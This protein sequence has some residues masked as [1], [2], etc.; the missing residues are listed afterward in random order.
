M[1]YPESLKEFDAPT[2]KQLEALSNDSANTNSLAAIN[3]LKE[4]INAS[5]WQS[6]ELSKKDKKQLYF[7]LQAANDVSPQEIGKVAEKVQSVISESKKAISSFTGEIQAHRETIGANVE[8]ELK[9][10][11]ELSLAEKL[12]YAEELVKR[13]ENISSYI[14]LLEENKIHFRASSRKR[15]LAMFKELDLAQQKDEIEHQFGEKLKIRAGIT[16]KFQSFDEEHQR[17]IS[18]FYELSIEERDKA[19]GRLEK[20]IEEK[21]HAILNGKLSKHISAKSREW[22][23]KSFGKL[24]IPK[25]EQALKMLE[26]HMRHEAE[27]SFKFEKFPPKIRAKHQKFF[28]LTYEEKEQELAKMKIELEETN[29]LD[30]KIAALIDE[31]EEKLDQEEQ[32]GT[33]SHETNVAFKDWITEQSLEKIRAANKE[34]A[35]ESQMRPRRKLLADFRKML[36]QKKLTP[37]QR[38]TRLEKFKALSGHERLE[39]YQKL[40]GAKDL[41][42][43]DEKIETIKNIDEQVLSMK[44]TAAAFE[45]SFK[46]DEAEKMYRAILVLTDNKDGHAQNRLKEISG[47]K[48]QIKSALEKAKASSTFKHEQTAFTLGKLLATAAWKSELLHGGATTSGAKNK[49]LNSVDRKM[50]EG[51]QEMTA[52]SMIVKKS[53]AEKVRTIDLARLHMLDGNRFEELKRTYA[54]LQQDEQATLNRKELQMVDKDGK[55]ITGRQALDEVANKEKA[56]QKV[57]FER[58]AR[59]LA[60]LTARAPNPAMRKMME[61]EVANTGLEVDLMQQAAA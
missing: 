54:P 25:R 21:Y 23:L 55:K 61:K 41:T 31:Y 51:L 35:F 59:E 15:K 7:E 44:K 42:N 30:G 28:D 36:A 60:L 48:M 43:T 39:E 1:G 26:A 5:I 14:K 50:Q 8:Q 20:L 47:Q 19:V 4:K 37:A 9:K 13:R 10:F 12:S 45:E 2:R 58:T 32:Q 38:K 24:T 29:K 17:L 18:N 53:R 27:L 22:A 52:G 57:L 11:K 46:M 3:R 33:I 56:L 40:K 6:D 16:A 49:D 34:T